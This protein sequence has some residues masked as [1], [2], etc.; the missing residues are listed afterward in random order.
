MA[1]RLKERTSRRR[2]VILIAGIVLMIGAVAAAVA[3][4]VWWKPWSDRPGGESSPVLVD[5]G[6][7]GEEVSLVGVGFQDTGSEQLLIRLS[8][9]QAELQAVASLP[10]TNGE[11]LSDEEIER[12]L[13]RLPALDGQPE[14]QLEFK[15]YG[16]TYFLSKVESI[17]YRADLRTSAAEK[18]MRAQLEKDQNRILLAEK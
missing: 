5:T 10:V 1:K 11:P 6:A 3:A 14:D 9:G 13:A 15:Q 2:S 17:G 16:D 4:V 7:A 8:P 18:E 12:V